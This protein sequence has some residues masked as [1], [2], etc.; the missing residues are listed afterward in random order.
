MVLPALGLK[1]FDQQLS[2]D[3]VALK[4]LLDLRLV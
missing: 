4:R 3:G 1:E 2:G